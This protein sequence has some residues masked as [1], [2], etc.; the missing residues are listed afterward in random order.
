MLRGL[1]YYR[2]LNTAVLLGV[3]VAAAVLAGA[4]MVGD[5]VQRSLLDLS[6]ARLG[7]VGMALASDRLFSAGLPALLDE[8]PAV[9]GSRGLVLLQ[10]SVAADNGRANSV[11]IH[12]INPDFADLFPGGD[13]DSS[14]LEQVFSRGE[15]QVFPSAVINAA[16]ARELGAA[17]GDELVVSFLQPGEIHRDSLY[18]R[19]NREDVISKMR[20]T[21]TRVLPEDGM[22]RFGLIPSQRT[23][24]SLFVPQRNLQRTWTPRVASMPYWCRAGICRD[25]RN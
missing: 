8:H 6:R 5:S 16:L 2:G 7:N 15:G 19:K 12:G 18:G 20:L 10:G 13:V 24:L 17:E 9:D 1:L 23:T 14:A 4:F 25:K 11:S 21:V 3:V 22:G